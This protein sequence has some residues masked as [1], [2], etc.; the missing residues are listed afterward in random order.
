[1]GSRD[2]DLGGVDP[3]GRHL[4][5]PDVRGHAARGGV[6]VSERPAA[7]PEVG[8]GESVMVRGLERGAEMKDLR[9]TRPLV[10]EAAADFTTI[11]ESVEVGVPEETV[12]LCSGR[13]YVL[14]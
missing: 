6:G 14:E 11:L 12:T 3:G 5:T 7:G 1:R 10:S 4:S 9:E 8:S 13:R 2:H